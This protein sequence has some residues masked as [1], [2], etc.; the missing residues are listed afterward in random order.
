MNN[1]VSEQSKISWYNFLG[2]TVLASI[3]IYYRHNDAV[4]VCMGLITGIAV[5]KFLEEMEY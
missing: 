2:V 4:G 3:E 5:G 1:C